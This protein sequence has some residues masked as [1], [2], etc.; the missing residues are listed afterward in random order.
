[1]IRFLSKNLGGDKY[2]R[3]N[4]KAIGGYK[5]TASEYF[6]KLAKQGIRLG[7]LAGYWCSELIHDAVPSLYLQIVDFVSLPS[8]LSFVLI[9]KS[10]WKTRK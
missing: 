10:G 4:T 3:D 5:R 9:Q 7:A 1:L 8:F 2:N 6:V